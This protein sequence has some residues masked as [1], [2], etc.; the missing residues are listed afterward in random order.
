MGLGELTPTDTEE[1]SGG[2]QSTY[3]TFKNPRTV[4]IDEN[5][6]HRHKQEYYDSVQQLRN[7]LGQDI[8]VPFG[9]FAAA[10]VAAEDE[11]NDEPLRNLFETITS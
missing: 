10:V 5:K 2:G 9:E 11:G 8:N 7:M 1:S 3:I 6:Q 4:D